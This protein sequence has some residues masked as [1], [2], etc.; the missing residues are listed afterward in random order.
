MMRCVVITGGA[1]FIGSHTVEAAHRRGYGVLVLD[2]LYSGSLSN[3]SSIYGSGSVWV[4]LV[5]IRNNEEI[6]HAV[7]K[8]TNKCLFEGI[9][10]LAAMINI[11]EVENNPHIAIDVNVK[12]T[13]NI[14][15][16]ARR[17]DIE[18]VVFAS[19]V[20]VYGEP[21]YL[22]IDENH[23]LEPINLYGETKLMAERI[24]WHY[25]R[26]YGLRPIALRYFNVYGPRMRP[27]PYAGV[28][29][30]FIESL[31][32]G[33]VPLIYGDG[34]QT[35]DFVYVK[36][37]AEANIKALGSDYIGAINIGSG[38]ETSINELYK[39]LCRLINYC[40]NPLYTAPRLGDV[41]RSLASTKKALEKLGWRPRTDILAGLKETLTYYKNTMN[42]IYQIKM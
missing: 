27:G 26:V 37:V 34:L 40:P 10:H 11:I 42:Q 36:D 16:L 21:K 35:R 15:E 8:Y 30:K 3:L 33:K 6:I 12:G 29:Y 22:P 4:E 2:N 14:L 5:D 1:G 20:A 32:K 23:P 9:V 19:S 41:R 24:L 18:R 7:K 28:I 31:L 39:T 17:L 13:I 38:R 25:S